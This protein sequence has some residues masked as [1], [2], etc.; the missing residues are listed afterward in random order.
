MKKLVV[1]GLAILGCALQ[2]FSQGAIELD[3]SLAANGVV[4]GTAGDWYSGT[5]G[6]EVWELN[7]T[8]FP[9][10]ID[11]ATNVI[12]HSLVVIGHPAEP[13][14]AEN[15]YRAERVHRNRWA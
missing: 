10:Q 2:A 1:A 15:R 8:A 12:A 14:R 6:L 13:V 4:L 3:N 11:S 9:S 7:G 5:Y